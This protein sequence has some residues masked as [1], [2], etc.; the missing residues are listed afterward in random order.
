[1]IADMKMGVAACTGGTPKWPQSF[2][3][4]AG[5]SVGDARA[6][7]KHG[8]S[9]PGHPL[10]AGPRP[11]WANRAPSQPSPNLTRFATNRQAGEIG[12]IPLW[13]RRE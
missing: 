6:Y 5:P 9:E 3:L 8:L 13:L 4:L 1:M 11:R 7:V 10:Q 12:P 2:R